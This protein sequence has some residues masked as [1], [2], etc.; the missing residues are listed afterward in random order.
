M[1]VC[2]EGV[3]V[4]VEVEE[5]VEIEIEVEEAE[6]NMK[7]RA[8]QTWREKEEVRQVDVSTDRYGIR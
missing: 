4:E 5:G 1:S 2:K 3:T 8:I 6:V 7:K